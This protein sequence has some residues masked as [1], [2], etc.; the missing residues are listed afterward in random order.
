MLTKLIVPQNYKEMEFRH[1]RVLAWVIYATVDIGTSIYRRYFLAEKVPISYSAHL[2]GGTAGFLVG[3]LV[4]RNLR[5][6][7][8]EKVFGWVCFFFY[9]LLLAFCIVWNVFNDSYF[10]ESKYSPIH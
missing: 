6:R 2:L 10:P 3:I 8:W 7:A 1:F 4:L 5:V 9:C